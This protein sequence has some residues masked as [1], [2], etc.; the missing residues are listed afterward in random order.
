MQETGTR[1]S[2]HFFEIVQRYTFY[3]DGNEHEGGSELVEIGKTA[4]IIWWTMK[5]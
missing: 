2:V 3:D 1:H 4:I 5:K